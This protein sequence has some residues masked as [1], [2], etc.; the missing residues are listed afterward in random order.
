M[1]ESFSEKCL[2]HLS[3]VLERCKEK[4]LVLNWEECHFMV[5]KEI[6]LGYIISNKRIDVN[7]ARSI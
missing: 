1:F 5:K 3:L 7:K 4:N 2:H 6:V